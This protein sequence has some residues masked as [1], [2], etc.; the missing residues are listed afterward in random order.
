MTMMMLI[1]T[2]TM[3]VM[4]IMMMMI[5]ECML[6]RMCVLKDGFTLSLSSHV[7]NSLKMSEMFE[8][9]D[10]W[11]MNAPSFP[12]LRGFQRNQVA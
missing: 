11:H 1:M 9:F 3:K 6:V 10:G 2:M 12:Q 5:A 7:L 8:H 4:M